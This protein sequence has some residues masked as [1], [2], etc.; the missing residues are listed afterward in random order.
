[1]NA[2]CTS[3]RR[4]YRDASDG[5]MPRP[6]QAFPAILS[7]SGGSSNTS[8][9]RWRPHWAGAGPSCRSKQP[10][11]GPVHAIRADCPCR[12]HAL[13]LSR[14]GWSSSRHRNR[15]QVTQTS[16]STVAARAAE[17]SAIAAR[18][19]IVWHRVATSGSDRAGGSRGRRRGRKALACWRID[20]KP[21]VRR[22]LPSSL[23]RK[24]A[25]RFELTTFTLAT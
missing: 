23:H 12:L 5:L 9:V 24:R 2:V 19:G 4:S 10:S 7:R 3:P 17:C 20:R 8:S 21:K 13:R 16:R 15:G 1:M 18:G 11:C 22:R 6:S 14:R 25:M